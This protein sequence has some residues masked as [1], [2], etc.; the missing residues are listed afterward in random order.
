MQI[1]FFVYYGISR[2]Q[3]RPKMTSDG[4]FQGAETAAATDC[5]AENGF[6]TANQS[7]KTD[8]FAVFSESFETWHI[9][10]YI[11]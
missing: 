5:K 8:F 11:F 7:G 6:S 4:L 9:T 3:S 10:C 2:R 1:I